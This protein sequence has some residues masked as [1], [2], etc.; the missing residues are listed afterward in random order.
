MEASLRSYFING[1][2]PIDRL[3]GSGVCETKML[4]CPGRAGDGSG[5]GYDHTSPIGGG[6]SWISWSRFRARLQPTKAQPRK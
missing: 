5:H 6:L 1:S 2:V 3:G 4:L